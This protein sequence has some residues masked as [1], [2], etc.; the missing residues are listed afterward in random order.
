MAHFKVSKP[1]LEA[2]QR[3]A[4]S[5]ALIGANGDIVCYC[6]DL[7]RADVENTIRAN[8]LT[9]VEEVTARTH[10]DFGLRRVQQADRRPA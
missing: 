2:S 5:R 7:Y 8:G 9:R 6:N 3:S 4:G 10:K 1:T